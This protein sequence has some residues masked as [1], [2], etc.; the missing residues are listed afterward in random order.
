MVC[1][2]GSKRSVREIVEGKLPRLPCIYC[3]IFPVSETGVNN[4]ASAS[5]GGHCASAS[6]SPLSQALFCLSQRKGS[7][8]HCRNIL[9]LLE[10]V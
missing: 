5:T 10:N 2:A 1:M 8:Q 9:A 3:C 4:V 6:V 7:F